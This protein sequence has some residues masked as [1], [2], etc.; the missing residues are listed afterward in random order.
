MNSI[1]TAKRVIEV[2]TLNIPQAADRI[3]KII[4][5]VFVFSEVKKE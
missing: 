5:M 1:D 2:Q 4:E 3:Y